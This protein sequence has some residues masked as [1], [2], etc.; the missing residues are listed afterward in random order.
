MIIAMVEFLE[1]SIFEIQS[2]DINYLNLQEQ[3]RI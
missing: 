1:Q 3:V 2:T